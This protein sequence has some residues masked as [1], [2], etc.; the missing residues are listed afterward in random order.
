MLGG[1]FKEMKVNSHYSITSELNSEHLEADMREL[2]FLSE[3]E[4]KRLLSTNISKLSNR[5]EGAMF[6]SSLGLLTTLVIAPFSPSYISAGLFFSGLTIAGIGGYFVCK[7]DKEIG[8]Y[9]RI[10]ETAEKIRERK[11]SGEGWDERV[12]SYDLDTIVERWPC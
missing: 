7:C 8:N 11:K 4:I 3:E 12:L 5:Y 1:Q 6:L 10:H 9:L 2:G